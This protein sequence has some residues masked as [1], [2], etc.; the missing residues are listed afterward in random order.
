MLATV[1]N[2]ADLIRLLVLPYFAYVAWRDIRTR[3]VANRLWVPL[4]GLALVLLACE[5]ATHERQ[6]VLLG[7]AISVGVVVPLVYALWRLGMFGGADAKAFFLIAVLYP[8]VP[9]Y[10][11]GVVGQLPIVETPVG[12]F[13]MTILANS[14]TVAASYPLFLALQNAAT[15]YRSTKMFAA[16]PVRW[17]DAPQRHGSLYRDHLDLDALRMYLD[18][19]GCSLEQLRDRDRRP[20]A[21]DHD[22]WAAAEFLDF[23]EGSAY[24][25]TTDQLRDGLDTLTS[26][27]VVLLSPGIPFLAP[28]FAGLVLSVTYGNVL[29]SLVVAIGAI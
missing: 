25:T 18:W 1:A 16:T 27:D 15:G 29:F 9:E 17:F 11:V 10:T 21:P 7:L 2:A 5:L 26:K 20:Q 12:A 14:M 8:T 13:S 4:A 22:P 6:R 24:K 23:I 3:R 19:R 28:L